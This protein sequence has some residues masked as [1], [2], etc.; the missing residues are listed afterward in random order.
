MS[1]DEAF[2][3]QKIGLKLGEHTIDFVKRMGG[4]LIWIESNTILTPAITLYKKLGFIAAP[5]RPTPFARCNIFMELA[6][7]N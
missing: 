3:G 2:Q 5:L 1:V 7:G 6:I 4:K